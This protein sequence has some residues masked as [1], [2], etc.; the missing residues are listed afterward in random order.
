MHALAVMLALA[1]AD[2]Q[3]MRDVSP[4]FD[5]Y[6]VRCHGP[7]HVHGGLRLDDYVSVLRGGDSGPVVIAG[8][9]EGS[10]LIAKVERRNRP[11]M[12]PRRKLPAAAIAKLRAWVA[13]GTLR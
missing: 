7:E 9:P 5:R 11:P 4:I 3:F 8:D 13:S 12:P 1:A 6:C 10:L 2:V